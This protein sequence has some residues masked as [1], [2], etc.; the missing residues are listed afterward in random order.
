MDFFK[1]EYYKLVLGKDRAME[2]DYESLKKQ[3]VF[4]CWQMCLYWFFLYL[5]FYCLV[6]V[7]VFL[8]IFC[9]SIYF[10]GSIEAYLSSSIGQ[11]LIV[12][13]SIFCDVFLWC[14]SFYLSFSY[15][16]K[17]FDFLG[18]SLGKK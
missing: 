13:L 4:A 2:R 3:L 18:F 11:S 15:V 1:H 5:F 14:L 12:L 7:I 10:P 17:R 8:F 9:L 6:Y 16:L